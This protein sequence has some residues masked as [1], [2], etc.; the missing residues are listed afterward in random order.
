MSPLLFIHIPKTAGTSLNASAEKIF[1]ADAIE[2]DYGPDVDHTTA[3]VKRYIYNAPTVDQYGF[4]EA[5]RD[6]ETKWVTGHFPAD[7]FLHLFGAQH[8]ISFVRDPVERVISEFRYRQKIGTTDLDFKSFY[9]SDAERNKQHHTIGIFPWKAFHLVGSQERY[10]DCLALLAQVQNLPFE[11]FERNIMRAEDE[12]ASAEIRSEIES[13][14]T[15]DCALVSEADMYLEK[16]FDVATRHEVF[17]YH[18][19]AFEPDRHFIGWAFYADNEKPV[20][21][22]VWADDKLQETVQASEH[23]T[24]LQAVGTPRM[25]HNGFR[26]V[27]D[28]YRKADRLDLRTHETGQ[29][30]FSWT[31]PQ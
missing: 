4:H 23:R 19:I 24:E 1:G 14:N 31:R 21:I 29:T 13:L 30:L 27:L 7:R 5:T 10:N 28:K 25:G 16:Q 9:T 12:T 22:E 17:C 8:T 18:D 11:A 6:A 15:L 3:N 20:Q 2:R 26:L